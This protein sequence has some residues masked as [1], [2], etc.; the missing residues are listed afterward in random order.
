MDPL[1]EAMKLRTKLKQLDR[2]EAKAVSHMQER[3]EEKRVV[4]KSKLREL[5][6]EA[7]EA[8]AED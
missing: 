2:A 1:K 5:L 6:A 7:H 8:E 3:Y 4:L